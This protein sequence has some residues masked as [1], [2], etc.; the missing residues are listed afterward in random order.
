MVRTA[1]AT[2][3]QY[4]YLSITKKILQVIRLTVLELTILQP[5]WRYLTIVSNIRSWRRQPN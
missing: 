3:Y 1:T 4:R 5:K 2:A